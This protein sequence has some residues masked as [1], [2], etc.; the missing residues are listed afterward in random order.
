MFGIKDVPAYFLAFNAIQLCAFHLYLP[1]SIRDNYPT[2]KSD[3][4]NTD[5]NIFYDLEYQKYFYD[6]KQCGFACSI[7]RDDPLE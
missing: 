4:C 6:C 7:H 1:R 2:M 5:I 3:C